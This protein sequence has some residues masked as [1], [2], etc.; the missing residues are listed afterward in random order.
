M[1]PCLSLIVRSHSSL[2]VLECRT[3]LAHR[4]C[5]TQ[6]NAI[7]KQ[8]S[9]HMDADARVEAAWSVVEDDR[10]EFSSV[11]N[12]LCT[13]AGERRSNGAVNVRENNN[14]SVSW[15]AES[16]SP[17]ASSQQ[18]LVRA[19]TPPTRTHPMDCDRWMEDSW[20]S[21]GCSA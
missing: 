10:R 1:L 14:Q 21:R 5:L 13:N 12:Q 3:T 11:C 4:S 17:L 9:D 15:E 16:V 18:R 2:V 19:P 7:E 20:A 8:T 6:R